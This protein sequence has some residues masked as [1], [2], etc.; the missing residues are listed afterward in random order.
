MKNM[1]LPFQRLSVFLFGLIILALSSVVA[2]QETQ[3]GQFQRLGGWEVH[4]NIVPT[5]FL[6]PQIA[7]QYGITRSRVR[8]L[9]NIAVLDATEADKPAVRAA[10]SGY[11]LNPIGQRRELQFQRVIEGDAIYF[12]ADFGHDDDE[13]LR[14]YLTIQR[15]N[16]IQTMRFNDTLY[17]SE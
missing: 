6:Q 11:F 13:N 5:T 3:G 15:G 16:N 8:S 7:S 9:L 4:H 2:A 1:N 14:F 12:L 10:V 17:H